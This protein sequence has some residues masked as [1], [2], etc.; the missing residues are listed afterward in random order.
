MKKIDIEN[1]GKDDIFSYNVRIGI[2]VFGTVFQRED[3]MCVFLVGSN[4]DILEYIAENDLPVKL[5]ANNLKIMLSL[6]RKTYADH[7]NCLFN[8]LG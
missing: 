5:V 8:S 2:R 4:E 3:S 6:L 7:L 1:M